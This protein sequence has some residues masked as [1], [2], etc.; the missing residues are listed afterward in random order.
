MGQEQTRADGG[1]WPW[2]G[3]DGSRC[4]SRVEGAMRMAGASASLGS[5]LPRIIPCAASIH[6]QGKVVR[7]THCPKMTRLGSSNS[8]IC[9]FYRR[10]FSHGV[11]IIRSTFFPGA[12]SRPR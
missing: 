7:S 6:T 4:C 12:M 2:P 11:H 3:D 8:V 10:G 5:R 9:W 1:R